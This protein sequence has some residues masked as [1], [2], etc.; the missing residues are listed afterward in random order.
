MISKINEKVGAWLLVD[1]NTKQL[2]A[3]E[4]DISTVTLNKKLGGET[5]WSWSQVCKI[6]DL[7]GC[8]LSDLR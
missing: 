5:D 1:G 7:I 6:A 2:L 8:E 4:L 3:N